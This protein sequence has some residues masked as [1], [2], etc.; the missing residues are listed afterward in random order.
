MSN[1]LLIYGINNNLCYIASHFYSRQ[2][3]IQQ[4]LLGFNLAYLQRCAH[5]H[6]ILLWYGIRAVR[7]SDKSGGNLIRSRITIFA[8]VP[9]IGNSAEE[10]TLSRRSTEFHDGAKDKE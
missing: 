8:E 6:E 7:G 2:W 10:Q 4:L 1:S 3:N 5:S 9:A